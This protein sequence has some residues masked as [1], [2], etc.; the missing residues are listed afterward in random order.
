MV[1]EATDLDGA[2]AGVVVP[3]RAVPD[4]SVRVV[5]AIA[6]LNVGGPSIQA[7]TLTRCL[8]E[9]SYETVLVRG[10]E[11]EREGNMDELARELGVLPVTVGSLRRELGFHDLLALAR[12]TWLLARE[13]PQILH[14]HAAK[15]G[16]VART[17][18]L[19]LGPFGPPVRVHTFHGHVLTGYFGSRR[20]QIFVAIER[21][22]AR[23]TTRLIAVSDEVR[24]DLVRLGIAAAEDIVV[25]PLGFD[26]NRFQPS[27]EEQ[28]RQRR[29][30]REELGFAYDET[31]VCVV[32]RLVPI[33]RV[34]RFLRI[35]R[36]IHEHLPEIRFLIVGDG[37]LGDELRNS[38]DAIALE[39]QLVWAG[40]RLDTER[41]YAASDVVVL[42]SDNE[43]TPVSLIEAQ[44]ACRPTVATAVGGVES[45][46]LDGVTGFV[47]APDDEA[48]FATA[49]EG[50]AV[51]P[52]RRTHL[53]QAGRR[54]VTRNFQLERLVDDID[55]LY[56]A[57]LE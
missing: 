25:V 57:L 8:R 32:A 22:L 46:V 51:D 37:G 36:C 48:G 7:I 50:L 35:A 33:K 43:G 38:P 3:G 6:R 4:R 34:D 27:Q 42:T 30:V 49:V 9:R 2:A 54:H 31:V 40:M 19:L 18:A 53:G 10:R 24:A 56:R 45:V 29:A 12:M 5:R 13:R 11:G 14:T 39:E 47:V 28:D 17:A 20:S 55:A 23:H 16:T 1:S 44:A 26:L 21:F 52:G 15:A 41:I